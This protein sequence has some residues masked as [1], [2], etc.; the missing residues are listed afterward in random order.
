LWRANETCCF[1][2]FSHAA[3]MFCTKLSTE[4]VNKIALFSRQLFITMMKTASYPPVMGYSQP[5]AVV[6]RL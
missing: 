6:Y 5:Q 1:C 4:K 2:C 3:T